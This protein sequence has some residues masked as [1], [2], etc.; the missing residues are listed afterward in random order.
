MSAN[1]FDVDRNLW[2]VLLVVKMRLKMNNGS[3]GEDV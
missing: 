3:T 1:I 2:A